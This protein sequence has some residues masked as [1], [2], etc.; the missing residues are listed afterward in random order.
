MIEPHRF[1]IYKAI[2]V[3]ALCTWL[4]MTFGCHFEFIHK[5]RCSSEEVN[6]ALNYKSSGQRFEPTSFALSNGISN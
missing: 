3:N 4:A 1:V 5:R 6:N 2:F